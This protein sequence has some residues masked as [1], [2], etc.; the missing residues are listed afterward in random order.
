LIAGRR[1]IA[2]ARGNGVLAR[3]PMGTGGFDASC[4][5]GRDGERAPTTS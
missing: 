3:D 5:I 1:V 4:S 2:G